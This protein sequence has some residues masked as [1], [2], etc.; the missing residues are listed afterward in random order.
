MNFTTTA[1]PRRH[2]DVHL[3]STDRS[4]HNR[5]APIQRCISDVSDW[6]GSRRLQLN[7][8]KTEVIWFGLKSLSDRDK[9]VVIANE[10]LQPVDSVRNLGV[11]LD[12]ELN[13]RT[14]NTKTTE[15]CFLQ[16]RRL[17]QI[18]C[19]LGR[20]VIASLV[21]TFILSRLDYCNALLA[22]LPQS[23]MAPLQRVMNAAARLVCNLRSWDHVTP[24]LIELHW[25]PITARVQYKLCLLVHLAAVGTA[26]DYLKNMLQPVSERASQRAP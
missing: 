5:T 9:A 11:Y 17:R 25:L 21:A 15:A 16:L 8:A 2:P 19:L 23:T 24:A 26:P 13:M 10:T 7:A 3:H 6:C 1:L 12:S 18:R 22:A 4:T 14:H 20:D